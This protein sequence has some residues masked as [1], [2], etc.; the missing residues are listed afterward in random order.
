[1][2]SLTQRLSG[3]VAS[4]VLKKVKLIYPPLCKKVVQWFIG[5]PL[6]SIFLYCSVYKKCT[7]D[8]WFIYTK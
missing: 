6:S 7:S 8:V 2:N 1:M 5:L 3:Y 4:V